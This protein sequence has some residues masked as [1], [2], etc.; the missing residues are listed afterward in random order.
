M[1]LSVD[2]DPGDLRL[3]AAVTITPEPVLRL[4]T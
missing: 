1:I 2:R 4:F 3:C